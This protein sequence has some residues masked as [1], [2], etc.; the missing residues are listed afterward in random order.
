MVEAILRWLKLLQGVM[1]FSFSCR[2]RFF[3][4]WLG[5]L[6]FFLEVIQFFLVGLGYILN[7]EFSHNEVLSCILQNALNCSLK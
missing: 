6:T 2:L 7:L 3:R 4:W 1:F 5:G